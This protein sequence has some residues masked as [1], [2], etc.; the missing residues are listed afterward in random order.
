MKNIQAVA[1][2]VGGF[3]GMSIVY[4]YAVRFWARGIHGPVIRVD[5][6]FIYPLMFA[7]S[8]GIYILLKKHRA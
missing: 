8:V 4:E 7:L 3:I 1:W 2:S 6:F 5:I